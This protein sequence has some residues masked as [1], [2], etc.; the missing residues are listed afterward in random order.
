MGAVRGARAVHMTERVGTLAEGKLADVNIFSATSPGMVCAAEHDPVAAVVRHS[1][2]RDIE[3]AIVDGVIRK[4][5]GGLLP[6]TV[7]SKT[8]GDGTKD[9]E[10]DQV[11]K[12]VLKSRDQVQGKLEKLSTDAG[13]RMLVKR[14]HIDAS[15]IVPVK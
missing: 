11:A 5:N 14:W 6:V 9:V 8:A 1:S 15:K 4:E 3:M 10:W 2:I 7:N 13:K 12:H